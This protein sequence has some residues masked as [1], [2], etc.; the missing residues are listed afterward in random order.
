MT[1][2]PN[3][4]AE[5]FER[6]RRQLRAFVSRHVSSAAETE[7]IVQE[8]FLRFIR[9]DAVDPVAQ[10]AAWLFRTARNRI[11]DHYRKSREERLPQPR[12]DDESGLVSEIT[13]L[14]ADDSSSPEME[15]LRTLVW[16]ELSKA[17]EELPDAQRDVFELTEIEGFTFRELAEDTGIPIATLL[18]RKHYAVKFLRTK[19][20]EIYEAFLT[21]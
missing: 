5:V 12:D 3:N 16:K 14:L 20:A 11:I 17:L 19:L 15:F 21:D 6:Y 2:Q 13:A 7:D 1:Q 4:P 18:S 9:T 10:I 8:V